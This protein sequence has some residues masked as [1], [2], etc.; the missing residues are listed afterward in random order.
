MYCSHLSSSVD[1]IFYP[2]RT[3]G[4]P[5][6]YTCGAC[7]AGGGMGGYINMSVNM[8]VAE[9]LSTSRKHN[10]TQ[11]CDIQYS[12]KMPKINIILTYTLLHTNQHIIAKYEWHS[13]GR[14]FESL[15]LHQLLH[16][17]TR[18]YLFSLSTG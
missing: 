12:Y 18:V 8:S 17:I 5:N 11:R 16:K 15:R 2:N 3:S 9:S 14:G 10:L 7:S 6:A 1:Q 13:W 4:T